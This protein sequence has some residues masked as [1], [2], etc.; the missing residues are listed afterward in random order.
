MTCSNQTARRGFQRR[1]EQGVQIAALRRGGCTDHFLTALPGPGDDF[2][3]L[4]RRLAS[5]LRGLGAGIVSMEIFGIPGGHEPELNDIFGGVAW[6]VTWVEEGCA[7]P[8]ALSGIQV[9]AVTG[10]AVTPVMV[11]GRIVGTTFD[12][13]GLQYCRLG[14][15]VPADLSQNRAVQTRAVFDLMVDGLAAAGMQFAQVL[16]TWFYNHD[17]LEWYDTFNDVRTSFFCENGVFDGLVPASTGIGGGNAA[18]AALTAGLLA[19]KPRSGSSVAPFAVPSPLQCP[20]LDYGSSFSRGVEF[21][22]GGF[23]RLYI[24]GTASIEPGGLS[25][26]IDDVDAQV[27]LTMDVV[28]AILDSR[29][30][31]WDDVS[32]AIAYFKCGSEVSSFHRCCAERGIP[33]MPV[34]CTNT[35]ICRDDLLF[36]IELDALTEAEI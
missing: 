14:G 9:W 11:G 1:T 25:V 3:S 28:L 18:G 16:R 27:A 30:M 19:V 8:D 33:P 35:D 36:E 5:V 4:S 2:S 21:E 7:H 22:A 34:L 6:P 12:A 10:P 23:R 20:A 26:H 17:M 31:T 24:S 29:G 32:R 13:D 15:L